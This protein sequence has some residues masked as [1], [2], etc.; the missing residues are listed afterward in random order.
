MPTSTPKTVVAYGR[1]VLYLETRDTPPQQQIEPHVLLQA[2]SFPVPIIII[3]EYRGRIHKKYKAP[4][5]R[6]D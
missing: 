2:S 4:K 6:S 1:G 3:I 5:F